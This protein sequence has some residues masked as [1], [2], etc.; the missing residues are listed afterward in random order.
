MEYAKFS[1]MLLVNVKNEHCWRLRAVKPDEKAHLWCSSSETYLS[2]WS[3]DLSP[4]PLYCLPM[5]LHVSLLERWVCSFSQIDNNNNKHIND[6]DD[7]SDNKFVSMDHFAYSNR[8]PAQI[9]LRRKADILAHLSSKSSH[10]WS[11]GSA[12]SACSQLYP[13]C[14]HD[15]H[16]QVKTGDSSLC[17]SLDDGTVHRARGL[18]LGRGLWIWMWT[19]WLRDALEASGKVQGLSREGTLSQDLKDEVTQCRSGQ[20]K[21]RGILGEDLT[22]E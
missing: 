20:R 6:G 18:D 13:Q 17:N 3:S 9:S 12:S 2:G 1:E 15:H 19:R 14:R 21:R 4:S 7:D 10:C 11:Q 16:W 22:Q 8:K 5:S